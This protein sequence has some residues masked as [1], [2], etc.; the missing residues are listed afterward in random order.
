MPA[1]DL[2]PLQHAQH[3]G[4]LIKLFQFSNATPI[5]SSSVTEKYWPC[6]LRS[7]SKAV[8]G[9]HLVLVRVDLE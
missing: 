6:T 2:V 7:V 4:P 9:A 5:Y 3:K 1:I 8:H